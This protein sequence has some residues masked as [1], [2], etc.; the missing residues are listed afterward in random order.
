MRPTCRSRSRWAWLRLFPRAVVKQSS[1]PSVLQEVEP[2]LAKLKSKA[3]AKSREFLLQRIHLLKKPRTNLQVLQHNSL[4]KFTYLN[5]FLQSHAAPVFEEV[6]ALY[7]D[8]L[9]RVYSSYFKSYLA[10]LLKLESPVGSKYDVL[11]TEPEKL[12]V[13]LVNR[14]AFVAFCKSHVR[15][16]VVDRPLQQRAAQQRVR[17]RCS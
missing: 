13:C 14:R 11:G 9:S 2:I 6:Q 12:K 3:V 8:T 16:Q 5:R 17:A 7:V 15:A 4:S 10:A 1:H